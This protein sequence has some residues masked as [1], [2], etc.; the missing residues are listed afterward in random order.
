MLAVFGCRHRNIFCFVGIG[1]VLYTKSRSAGYNN[2]S[3]VLYIF[4]HVPNSLAIAGADNRSDQDQNII[5][6]QP[7][8]G[9]YSKYTTVPWQCERAT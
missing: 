5:L 9:K 3:T 6:I 4:Y 1:L 7:V 2:Q 8:S